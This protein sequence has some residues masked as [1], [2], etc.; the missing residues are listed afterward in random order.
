M[1]TIISILLITFLLVGCTSESDIDKT[2]PEGTIQS[3]YIDCE[4]NVVCYDRGMHAAAMSCVYVPN[5]YECNNEHEVK[6][7]MS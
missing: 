1:K 6:Y 5:I 7:E 4:Y 3:Y 2:S